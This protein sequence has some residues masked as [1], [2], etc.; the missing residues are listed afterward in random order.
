MKELVLYSKEVHVALVVLTA[1]CANE[2]LHVDLS[3]SLQPRISRLVDAHDLLLKLLHSIRPQ[4][5][6]HGDVETLHDEVHS[7]C[8]FLVELLCHV[9]HELPLLIAEVG[10]EQWFRAAAQLGELLLGLSL[11][12]CNAV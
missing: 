6:F 4:E 5:G 8:E 10:L 7:D 3:R 1:S 11:P 12:M 2:V 9:F